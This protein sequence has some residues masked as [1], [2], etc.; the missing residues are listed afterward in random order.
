MRS[1][2]SLQQMRLAGTS[3]SMQINHLHI[4]IVWRVLQQTDDLLVITD[5][6]VLKRRL[7][8]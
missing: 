1:A 5:E 2:A 7:I 8:L 6:K 4:T 3:W